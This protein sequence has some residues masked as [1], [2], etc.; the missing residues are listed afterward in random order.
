MAPLKSAL[1]AAGLSGKK[2]KRGEIWLVPDRS[3]EHA[4]DFPEDRGKKGKRKFH[5]CRPV[6][7]TQCESVRTLPTVLVAPCSHH[8]TEIIT[9][10]KIPGEFNK[11]GESTN[12]RLHLMQYVLLSHL[13]K[14]IGEIS[15]ATELFKIIEAE[16]GRVFGLL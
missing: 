3:D 9:S 16:T 5:G 2:T 7:I 15:P 1:K 4:I 11:N 8:G 14:K 6:L 13:I 12:A 10:I